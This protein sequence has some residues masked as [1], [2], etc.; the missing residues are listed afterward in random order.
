VQQRNY[1]T[2][3]CSY[4]FYTTKNKRFRDYISLRFRYN[5][6]IKRKERKVVKPQ[7]EKFRFLSLRTLWIVDD[8]KINDYL[9]CVLIYIPVL[10]SSRNVSSAPLV[11]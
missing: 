11:L 10:P 4:Y 9:Q 2:L 7:R 8:I 1:T 6:F 5:S 3:F